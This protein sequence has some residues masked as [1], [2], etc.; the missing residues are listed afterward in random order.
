M[1]TD[2]TPRPLDFLPF[3]VFGEK[4]LRALRNRVSFS[5]NTGSVLDRFYCT[6]IIKD[7]RE[8]GHED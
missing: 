4:K 1:L 2:L 5:F 7:H 8:L 3:G 6:A